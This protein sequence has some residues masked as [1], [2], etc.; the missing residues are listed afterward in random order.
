MSMELARYAGAMWLIASTCVP[1]CSDSSSRF[2][3]GESCPAFIGP[4]DS[5]C[6]ACGEILTSG[7]PGNT[8]I[9]EKTSW[10]RSIIS[11][12]GPPRFFGGLLQLVEPVQSQDYGR[13]ACEPSVIEL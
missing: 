12:T 7:K 10:L 11:S 6:S 3:D 2:A 1:V 4:G 9:P 13:L 5:S 8:G